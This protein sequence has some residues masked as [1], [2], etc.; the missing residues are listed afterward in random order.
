MNY[1]SDQFNIQYLPHYTLLVKTGFHTDTILVSDEKGTV[2]VMMEYESEQ[3]EPSA[4]Q[5]LSLPFVRVKIVVPH[6]SLIFVPNELFKEEALEDY[7]QFLM[8]EEQGNTLHQKLNLGGVTAVY[9]YDAILYNRWKSLFPEAQFIP[10]FQVILEQAQQHIPLQGEVIGVHFGDQ[11]ADLFVFLNGQ[12][13]LYNT[14]EVYSVEDLTYY[15]L[16]I[17]SSFHIKDK[18][19]KLLISGEIPEEDYRQRL[20][21]LAERVETLTAKI[22][23]SSSDEQVQQQLQGLN[24]L[25]EY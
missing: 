4:L 24:T 17:F 12:F 11:T 15:L 2:Q 18:V 14:F 21:Q 9:Q 3:P 22:K 5:L 1:T 19:Q 23:I 13:Q 10:E 16:R 20:A 6:Q 8:D 25:F 7:T